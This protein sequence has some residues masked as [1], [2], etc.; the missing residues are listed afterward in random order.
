MSAAITGRLPPCRH[1][2][3]RRGLRSL[4]FAV[5]SCLFGL[6][7]VSA[8]PGHAQA[9]AGDAAKI[10]PFVEETVTTDDNVF[11]ISN[12]V[13]PLTAI[14]SPS[15]GDTYRTTSVGLSADVPVSLQR[16]RATLTTSANP[17]IASTSSTTMV[18]TCTATGSGRSAGT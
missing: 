8:R 12:Q 3:R 15:R 18:T 14:G 17:T 10:T 9:Q 13:D 1:G 2:A 16:F 5:G 11:R 6:L 4:R 7:V